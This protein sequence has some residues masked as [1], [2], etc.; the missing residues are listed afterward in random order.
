MFELTTTMMKRSKFLIVLTLLGA[1]ASFWQCGSDPAPP[2]NPQ[3]E[4]LKKL[5]FT[6]KATAVTFNAT[7]VTG[8][9]NFEITMAGTL[10]QPTFNYTTTGRPAG[11]KTPWDANGTFTFPATDFATI[12]TRNDNIP[13]TYSVSAT[14]LQMTFTYAGAGFTGRVGNVEGSWSFTFGL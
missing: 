3:D 11:I 10:G 7:P 2:V 1:S 5:S 14:Q 13:V 12:I 6:W 4:Q 9:E 8:Y